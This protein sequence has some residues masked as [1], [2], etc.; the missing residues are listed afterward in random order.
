MG[1]KI[2]IRDLRDGKF[3]WIDKAALKLITAKAGHRGVTVYAWLCYFAHARDQECFPSINT[4]AEECRVSGRT[5]ARTIKNLEKVRVIAIQ[6]TCGKVNVYQLLDV[7]TPV[8]AGSRPLTGLSGVPLTAVSP[9]QELTEQDLFNKAVRRVYSKPLPFPCPSD[10][11][12]K[13]VVFLCIELKGSIDLIAFLKKY[14]VKH[15]LPPVAVLVKVCEQFKAEK[16]SIKNAW[17]WFQ[18]V[19]RAETGSF[20]ASM[21]VREH[22]QIKKEPTLIGDILAGIA[23]HGN[24][25]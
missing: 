3:L 16:A 14:R 23:K 19:V 10:E 21:Q 18:R 24:Q 4:L 13:A 17:G 2:D 20:N 9:E 7:P 8:T 1:S 11:Q 12:L 5:I 15:C 6:H 22:E 25:S